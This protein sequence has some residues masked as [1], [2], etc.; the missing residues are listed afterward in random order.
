MARKSHKTKDDSR[1][2]LF[3]AA[4][5]DVAFDGWTDA[6]LA[7]AATRARL[8]ADDVSTAFPRGATDLAQ[9]FSLWADTRMLE[10]LPKPEKLASL[11]IRD[12]VAL[13]VRTRLELLAPHRQAL[14]SALAYLA[15]PP[16]NLALPKMVWATADAIWRICGDTS[17]DYNH[18]TK[19]LLLS[20]VLSSTTLYW[21]NDK[22]AGSEKTWEF[23]ARRID[24]VMKVGGAIGKIKA[25]GEV[26]KARAALR[27]KK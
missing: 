8:D 26:L 11:R 14:S 23:L 21:L 17:A 9:Y 5:P 15:V 3:E 18:Y 1:R 10:K 13:C 6:V 22:S 7:Q 4:L 25:K 27:R 2:R 16:R 20:G 19:R 24:D 12:R